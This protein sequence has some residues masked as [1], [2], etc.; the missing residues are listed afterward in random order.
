[1]EMGENWNKIK[2]YLLKL[3]DEDKF[4]ENGNYCHMN[5]FLVDHY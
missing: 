5:F 2:L 3:R 1:M 4:I